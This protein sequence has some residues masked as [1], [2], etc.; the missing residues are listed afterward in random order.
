MPPEIR[1]T[2]SKQDSRIAQRDSPT[3]RKNSLDFLR[4]SF[5]LCEDSLNP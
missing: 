4:A 3:G 2:I 1:S 5:L